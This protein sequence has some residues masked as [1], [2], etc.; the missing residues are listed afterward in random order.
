MWDPER[1]LR[2][3]QQ[4]AR[5]FFDLVDQVPL[6]DP[7]TIVDLGCGPGGLTA[8]FL[9]RFPAA[10]IRGLDAASEMIRHAQRRAVPG[11]LTFEQAEI[12]SWSAAEPVDLVFSNACLHW[13]PDHPALFDHLLP[14][15]AANGVLAFQIPNNSGEASHVLLRELLAAP[16]WSQL[17][18]A[19]QLPAVHA[20]QHYDQ[21]LSLNL[22]R[23]SPCFF[24]VFL[25]AIRSFMDN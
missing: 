9:Q 20:A 6:E 8:T 21:S 13:I 1:Y 12:M 18:S 7:R 16:Q 23:Y 5:P 19:V 4:R 2:Y 25:S 11:R 17:L 10:K 22:A 24:E 3:G 15:V 14:Q